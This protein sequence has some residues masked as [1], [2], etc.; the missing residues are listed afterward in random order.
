MSNILLFV[1][2]CSF[3]NGL[4]L[5]EYTTKFSESIFNNFKRQLK[6]NILNNNLKKDAQ[7]CDFQC[8]LDSLH[9]FVFI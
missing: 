7:Y 8:F 2:L 6:N 9:M 1:L 5:N 4:N 3:S